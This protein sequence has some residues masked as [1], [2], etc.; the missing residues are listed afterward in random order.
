MRRFEKKGISECHD[1]NLN[2]NFAIEYIKNGFNW[3][4]IF[5][6]ASSMPESL[7]L[8]EAQKQELDRRLQAY[9]Q[10]PESTISWEEV[11]KRLRSLA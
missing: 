1:A 2:P 11:K 8:T 10:Q 6:I 5:G 3:W 9:R 7:P 4:K